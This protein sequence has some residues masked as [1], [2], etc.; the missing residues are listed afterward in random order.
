MKKKKVFFKKLLN[1]ISR[2]CDISG[3]LMLYL[4]EFISYEFISNRGDFPHMS[5][6]VVRTV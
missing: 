2:K 4:A 5:K 6:T 1:N 3:N